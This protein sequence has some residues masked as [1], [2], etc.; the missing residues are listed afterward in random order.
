MRN[1]IK[2]TSLVTAISLIIALILIF[3]QPV[4]AYD[5]DF[6]AKSVFLMEAVT[7]KI[8]YED[9]A[10]EKLHPASVTKIMT[11]LLVM[12]A[13]DTGRIKL[14]DVVQVSENAASMGGSQVYLAPGEEITV[15]DLLK[16]VVVSSANDASVALA[17]SISGSEESFVEIMNER[18]AQLG[19]VNTFFEN[20]NGLDDTT[21]KHLTTAR[22]IAIMSAELLRYPKILEYSSIWMDSIRNGDFTLTNTNRLIRFYSGANGLK[23]GSTSKAKFCISATAIRNDM[24]LIAVVMASPT[25]DTRNEIAKKLLDYGF[26]NYMYINKNAGNAGDIRVIGGVKSNCATEYGEFNMVLER[27]SGKEIETKIILDE[28]IAAPVHR[29]DLVGKIEYTKEGVKIGE[30]DI[31]AGEDI[32]RIGYFGLLQKL[33]LKYLMI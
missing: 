23:T 33:L 1:F 17:E 6:N 8:L 9:N 31:T 12:E 22:D 27:G 10:D 28:S 11:M 24:Q 16:S 13:I 20:T 2:N 5:F 25:R 15:E 7:G 30:I 21:E 29:G 3:G 19:M 18:A 14:D 26:A 4:S 32:G